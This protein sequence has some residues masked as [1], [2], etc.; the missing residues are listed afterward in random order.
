MK[1]HVIEADM[2]GPW[3]DAV[4]KR[5]DLGRAI[6]RLA[7]RVNEPVWFHDFKE[8]VAGAPVVML[9]CSDA[10][11]AQVQK[12]PEF[13][14][15]QDLWQGMETQ[16]APAIQQY[17]TQQPPAPPTQKRSPRPPRP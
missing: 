16:R 6:G 14:K 2:S 15:S 7:A 1:V 9:E 8:P 10:F 13:S 11:L 3:Q 12:L 4:Q 5:D 17:F